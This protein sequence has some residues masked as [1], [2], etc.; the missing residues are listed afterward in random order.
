[1]SQSNTVT[2]E[3]P[4]QRLAVKAA[5][6][7]RRSLL[8]PVLMI[9][10]VVLVALA[11]LL[12]WL[13]GGRYMSTDDSYVDAAKVSLSTDVT[14]LVGAV[15]VRDNQHVSAGQPLFALGQHGFAIAVAAA[16]AQLAQAVLDINAAKHGYQMAQAQI[17]EQQALVEKDK[18]DLARYAAVVASGGATRAQYDDARFALQGDEAKLQQMQ[19]AAGQ[20]LAKLSGNADID[21]AK[22]PEY[23]NALANLNQALL[24]QRHSIVRAPFSGTVTQ[25]EQLQ[26]GMLLAAGT[27]AFGLVS[28][29]DIFV[30]A[31]PK[32]DQLTWVR[33][34]QSV[35]I[36]VDTYPGQQWKGEVE[37]IAPNSGSEFS[38]LPA[39]NSSGNWVK[40]VQRIPVRI[41]I[42]SG[43]ADMMLRAGMST[44][45]SIDTHHHRHLADLF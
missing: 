39:Q 9:G 17:A 43:P 24:N 22:T 15:Y 37:S 45:I 41:K 13:F 25:V 19:A 38:V 27:A 2:R 32:E 31:Q 21:P 8:R 16:Q 40:V 28:D 14:G 6:P 20:Q 10:G 35:N 1:M 34:G 42:L 23:L 4:E 30:T 5:S 36:S 33:P 3:Q 26:P 29:S 7:A 44:E 12:Y 18:A 11:C